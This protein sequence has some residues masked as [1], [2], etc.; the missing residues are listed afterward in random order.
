MKRLFL[1]LL[2][3]LSFA[4]ACEAPY[5]EIQGIKIG[6]EFTGG[7]GFVKKDIK[8]LGE[9]YYVL[10]EN[11]KFFDKM[12]V[13]TDKDNK[14]IGI[15]FLKNYPITLSN[16]K[17]Q[18]E[19]VIADYKQFVDSLENRWGSFDKSKAKGVYSNLGL[20]GT[21]FMRDIK[22]VSANNSPK[23]DAIGQIKVFL[24]FKVNDEGMMLGD[25]Q[26]ATFAI[27]YLGKSTA[28]EIQN[29]KES[30]TDGF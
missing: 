19:K 29:E 3:F 6:C 12:E 9:N 1:I 13:E 10:S 26:D 17:L 11:V 28:E 25:P 18:E 23:S 21:L 20:T 8:S 4:F 7:N 22:E 27:A 15:A 30:I 24:H 5:E 14:V 2:A 16:M